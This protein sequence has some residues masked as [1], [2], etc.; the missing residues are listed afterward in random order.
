MILT[1]IMKGTDTPVIVLGDLNDGERSNTLNIITGQPNYLQG[2]STGGGDTDLYSAGT[3]QEYRSRRNVY[4][5]HIHND[6]RDSLDHILVSQ[7]FY[8]NSK[9]RIWSFTGMDIRNDHLNDEDHKETGTTDHGIVQ[10]TF[11]YRP[12]D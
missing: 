8:D 1:G 11:E 4:Y 6:S 12:A 7:E 3:L 2:L 5:T 10:S 9:K